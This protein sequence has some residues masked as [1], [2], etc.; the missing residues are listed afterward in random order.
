[1]F[2]E[3]YEGRLGG[4]TSLGYQFPDTDLSVSGAIRYENVNLYQPIQPTPPEILA[5]LGRSNLV[6]FRLGLIH[7]TRDSPF[8]A[9]DGHY[10]EM[11]F[12]QV[13]GTFSYPRFEAEY[14][15]Y[16]LLHERPDTSGRHTLSWKA[17]VGITGNDTPVYEEYFA[18]GFS[19]M[20]GFNFRGVS[21]RTG[22]VAVGGDFLLLGSLEYMFPI[23]A[24]DMVRGVTFVDLGT[25]E[26]NVTID[27][28]NFRVAP[29]LGLRV[30]VPALGPAPIALDFAFPVADAAGDKHRTFS[31]FIGFGR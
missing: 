10:A 1:M 6:G 30:T 17:K 21:P 23:T 7:D 31:F 28:K 15:R 16:F 26:R 11:S 18:G 3:W 29:G 14:R 8:L 5:D 4:R 27:S 20:R 25:V 9:T 24:D 13:V 19:T 22:G 2:T 12:E